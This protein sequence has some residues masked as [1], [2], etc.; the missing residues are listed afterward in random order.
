MI[1]RVEEIRIYLILFN[2]RHQ[3]PIAEVTVLQKL[4][5]AVF[6]TQEGSAG[7]NSHSTLQKKKSVFAKK[8]NPLRLCVSALKK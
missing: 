4:N 7:Q 2:C 1:F 5:Y 6:P 3:G 8:T